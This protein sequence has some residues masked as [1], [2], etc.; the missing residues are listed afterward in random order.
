MSAQTYVVTGVDPVLQAEAL[1]QLLA[2]LVGDNDPTLAVEDLTVPGRAAPG[3]G[4]SDAP[5][6][7]EGRAEVVA[8][9]LN[10]AQSPPF[11]TARRVV[12]LHE[13][14]NLSKQDAEPLVEYLQD[15]MDTTTLVVV[16]GGGRPPKSLTDALRAAK[17][18]GVG[19]A[20]ERTGDVLA[21]QLEDS[22]I[23]LEP[24]AAKRVTSHLGEDAGRVPQLVEVLTSAFG[25]GATLEVDDVDPY[26]GDAGSVPGYLLTNA[27]ES[28][29]MAGALETLRRMLTATGPGQARPMHPLQVM[30]MLHSYYRRV[31]RLDDPDVRS[32]RDAVAALDGRIKEYPARK[33]LEAARALGSDG[34]RQAYDYL[35][36]AD[37]DI[38]GARAIPEDGVMEVLVARLAALHG[39]ARGA[40][41]RRQSER[42]RR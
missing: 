28:G 30:G 2:E 18:V 1:E 11:M 35:F 26:L 21:Q 13:A 33:A 9:A 39:R 14:G 31:A 20:S 40:P 8:A 24:E 16:P 37:L 41:R 32:P 29:D 25:S 34:L 4:E 27:I 22:A 38:K 10:A 15:P 6:G 12:V 17:A 7:A 23:T 42:A 36:A 19:P 5:T 3:E